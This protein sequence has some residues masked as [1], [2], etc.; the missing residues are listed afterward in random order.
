MQR[1]N[2]EYKLNFNDSFNLIYGSVDRINPQVIYINGK[3]WILPQMKGENKTVIYSILNTFK[4]NIKNAILNSTYFSNNYICDFDLNIPN[5]ND[6]KKHFLSFEIYLKQVNQ[7]LIDL[8]TIKPYIKNSFYNIINDFEQE[9]RDNA[10][11]LTKSK[12]K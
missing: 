3:T 10:F 8:K 2:K 1:L 11:A 9:L 12:H 5:T 4:K 7:P 6:M